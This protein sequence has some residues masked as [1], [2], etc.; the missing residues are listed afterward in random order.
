MSTHKSTEVTHIGA[1]RR[2]GYLKECWRFRELL[3]FLTWRDVIIRYKQAFLGIGWVLLK[4]LV[5]MAIFTF[6]FSTI[7]RFPSQ[8][9]SYPLFVLAAMVPWQFFAGIVSESTVALV[10]NVHL[11]NKVYFP[12][13]LLP[14][15]QIFAA[16]IELGVSTLLLLILALFL[17]ELSWSHLWSLPLLLALVFMLSLGTA[18]WI[19]AIS[20]RYRDTRFIASALVQFGVFLS[21]VGYG[22]FMI[23]EKWQLIYQLNPL[24]GL[25]E[26]MR[27]SL[28]GLADPQLPLY[29]ATS[30][31]C[32]LF[33][34][35]TGYFYFRRTEAF[36]VD[37]I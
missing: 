6:V 33:L 32:S 19:S 35:V 30:F 29:L 4:P 16:M 3:Y 10:Q 28:F 34:L 11:I 7:A 24:V 15:G 37:V 13:L 2:S 21:P 20:V 31:S 26:G 18:F 1:N 14:I 27:W 25:I 8:Q 23:P 9:I 17:G 5:T 12:R 22:T 36:C